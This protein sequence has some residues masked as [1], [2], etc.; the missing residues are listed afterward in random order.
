MG[1]N[2]ALVR[3][4]DAGHRLQMLGEAQGVSRAGQGSVSFDTSTIQYILS[5]R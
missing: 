4:E 3:T 1:C 2:Q 5:G